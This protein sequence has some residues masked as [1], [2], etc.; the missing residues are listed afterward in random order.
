[1]PSILTL[2]A[3]LHLLIG[4]SLATFQDLSALSRTNRYFNT[5]LTAVLYKRA[6]SVSA[7]ADPHTQC[8]YDW[9]I[10]RE[11]LSTLSQLLRHGGSLSQRIHYRGGVA[12]SWY[13]WFWRRRHAPTLLLAA[14]SA[15][16][17]RAARFLLQCGAEVNEAVNGE[18]PL[19]VAV[20]IRP[21]VEMVKVLIEAG[22]DVCRPDLVGWAPLASTLKTWSFHYK[23]GE[24]MLRCRAVAKL[25]IAHG[26]YNG[27]PMLGVQRAAL[28]AMRLGPFEDEEEEE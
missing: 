9:A 11:R 19:H 27:G 16:K 10:S 15:H 22:A 12:Q 13:G 26:A 23:D 17:I 1:M 7:A 4:E 20:H 25:L 21:D 18:G 28:A 24:I 5:T 2:A 14:V 6:L 8:V 3:E